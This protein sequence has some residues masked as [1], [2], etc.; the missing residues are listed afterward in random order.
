MTTTQAAKLFNIEFHHYVHINGKTVDTAVGPYS[1]PVQLSDKIDFI[2]GIIGFPDIDTPKY[3]RNLSIDADKDITPEVIRAR[4]NVSA[5]TVGK[6]KKNAHA[7]AEFQAQY[8]SPSD[9]KEFWRKYV[10]FAPEQTVEKV[11]GFND[12]DTPGIEASLDIEYIMGV[13]PGVTTW[14]YSMKQFNFWSDLTKWVGELN[15]ESTVP[16]V[17]SVSYGSQGDYPS[18]AYRDR[19]NTEFQKVGTRGVSI[20]FASGDDGA[21]CEGAGEAS[22]AQKGC[23][24]T[25]YPSFPAT[26]PYVT[27]VGAT[28]FISGNSGPE[29][30]VSL[31][32]SGG[33]FSQAFPTQSYQSSDIKAYLKS[34]VTLPASCSFN[35]SGRG[36]PDVAALGDEYFQVVNGGS[37]IP[38]G[39]TSASSPSFAAIITLLNDLR[40]DNGKSTLGFLNPFLYKTASNNPDAFFDVTEGNNKN[41]FCCKSGQEDGFLCAAGWDPVTGL[42]TP[43]YDVLKNLV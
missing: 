17:H 2:S 3:R 33:G 26:C 14:F 25:F 43:N 27:S 10:T 5:K 16:W 24:C 29:A 41:S 13:S 11:I 15:N 40:L 31:F 30:A 37:T 28:K 9:L 19:L 7:V 35:A 21:G 6:N 38:V 39:G 23:D 36:T 32:K 34:G 18:V 4:Y 12:P 22:S 1:V 20:V 8:Y 42:G